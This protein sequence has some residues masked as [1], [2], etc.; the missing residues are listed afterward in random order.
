MHINLLL[1]FSCSITHPSGGEIRCLFLETPSLEN[2]FLS[3]FYKILHTLSDIGQKCNLINCIYLDIKTAFINYASNS[4]ASGAND[5][6]VLS[7]HKIDENSTKFERNIEDCLLKYWSSNGKYESR[8]SRTVQYSD[9]EYIIRA[10]N[11]NTNLLC[12]I[13]HRMAIINNQ[14]PSFLLNILYGALSV[15]GY[16]PP[17]YWDDYEELS[18]CITLNAFSQSRSYVFLIIVDMVCNQAN[19]ICNRLSFIFPEPRTPSEQ[20]DTEYVCIQLR[21]IQECFKIPYDKKYIAII[22]LGLI[23]EKVTKI[24][25][26]SLILRSSVRELISTCL[27]SSLSATGNAWG[28]M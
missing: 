23:C 11:D 8:L 3:Y 20:L 13:S 14:S 21:I 2:K 28:F 15:L 22:W 4:R 5:T 25:T 6:F 24:P 7:G 17:L 16:P 18:T 19:L 27:I 9:T 26:P 1:Y 10:L 12:S